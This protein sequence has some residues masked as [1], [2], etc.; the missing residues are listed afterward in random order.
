MLCSFADA[1]FLRLFGSR[2]GTARILCAYSNTEEKS[3]D[4]LSF[5]FQEKL[6]AYRMALS[7]LRSP[8]IL[9]WAPLEAAERTEK[10][11]TIPVAA[12]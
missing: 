5:A 8:P 6:N 1:W 4:I 9:P 11:A 3:E 10:R 7:M 2:D 12:I